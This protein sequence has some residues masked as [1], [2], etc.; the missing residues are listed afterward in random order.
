MFW[1]VAGALV[2]ALVL[3]VN[4]SSSSYVVVVEPGERAPGTR[5]RPVAEPPPS[6]P[7]TAGPGDETA[8]SAPL[9]AAPDRSPGTLSELVSALRPA[10]V[11]V[12]YERGPTRVSGTGFVI[13]RL[14]RIATNA[15]VVS[16]TD[17]PAIMT[18]AGR[19]YRG[20]VLARSYADDLALV[21]ADLP[22]EVPTVRIADS[23]R[24]RIGEEILVFGFPMG[25]FSEVT[26]TP[27]IVSSIRRE[28]NR[29][30]LSAPI[31]T[32]NSG[33]PVFDRTTGEVVAVV[34]S[35]HRVGEAMGFSIPANVL[36]R[37]IGEHL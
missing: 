25:L 14:G 8:P 10:V 33:G 29:F 24:V 22:P 16:E 19:S 3:I 36:R 21:H 4:A 5:D 1:Y 13:D 15:H 28:E 30:Q 6:V 31:N 9:P 32:G 20:R 12:W 35:K 26:V 23:D 34:V 11:Y 2:L 27:G 37:F 17:S 7:E 18:H